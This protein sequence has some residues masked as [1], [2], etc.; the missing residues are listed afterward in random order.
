MD[1][2]VGEWFISVVTAD[3]R[4]AYSLQVA[5][6]PKRV[7][8]DSQAPVNESA[9]V[10]ASPLAALATLVMALCALFVY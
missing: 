1:Y 9:A 5:L 6:I 10:L 4:V 3:S 2:T 8:D 7:V